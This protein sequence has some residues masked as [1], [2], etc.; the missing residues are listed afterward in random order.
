VA[1]NMIVHSS[2]FDVNPMNCGGRSG[3][4]VPLD[5]DRNQNFISI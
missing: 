5:H 2:Q 4:G 1:A 3:T